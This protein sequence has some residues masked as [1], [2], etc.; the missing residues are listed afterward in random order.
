[1]SNT[2]RILGLILAVVSIVVISGCVE[3]DDIVIGTGRIKFINLEGGF[4]G[5]LANNGNQYDPINLAPEFQVE[6]LRVMF[7]LR[8]LE[9]QTNV[10][11]WG[12]MVEILSM[13]TL[14]HDGTT[15]ATGT[16]VNYTGCIEFFSAHPPSEDCLVYSYSDDGVLYLHHVN[17]GFNCCPLVTANISIDDAGITIEEIELSGDCFCLCLFDLYYEITN[18]QPGTY[19]ISIIEPYIHEDD[20]PL[21][22][23]VDLSS[24][25]SG[26]H[27]VERHHYPWE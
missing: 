22:F 18:L 15:N 14:D 26:I 9:N 12:S 17:A 19:S 1:M 7:S 21:G 2:Y 10:H 13:T 23:T 11:M 3:K 5:I 16:L 20:E 8:I 25:P 27:C 24:T 6:G 4:Y